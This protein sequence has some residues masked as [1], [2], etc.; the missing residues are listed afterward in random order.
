MKDRLRYRALFWAA[1]LSTQHSVLS[2]Q[3]RKQNRRTWKSKGNSNHE[4][5]EGKHRMIARNR[6]SGGWTRDGDCS[7]TSARKAGLVSSAAICWQY[8]SQEIQE[9]FG[10]DARIIAL[11]GMTCVANL[12]EMPVGELLRQVLCVLAGEY[13]A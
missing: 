8:F 7:I 4:G 9:H 13:V 10:Q 5:H 1:W 3:P 11:H 12:R 2:I 6:V